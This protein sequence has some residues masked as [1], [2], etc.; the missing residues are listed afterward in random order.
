MTAGDSWCYEEG[1]TC[2]PSGRG[3]D[4]LDQKSRALYGRRWSWL[5][6]V[7]YC[8]PTENSSFLYEGKVSRTIRV[9]RVITI[10]GSLHRHT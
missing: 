5:K 2:K 6:V 10:D 7:L 9:L 1:E 8:S 3:V 4:G